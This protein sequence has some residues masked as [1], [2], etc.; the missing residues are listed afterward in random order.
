MTGSRKV[1]DVYI[2]AKISPEI[3]GMIPLIFSGGHLVWICG[4]KVSAKAGVT[5]NTASVLK[6][7]ILDSAPWIDL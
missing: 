7:E 1:K 6:A 4:L 3:R 2:D 5:E